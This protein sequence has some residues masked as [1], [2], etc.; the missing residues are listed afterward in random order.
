MAKV[1][2]DEKLTEEE[3]LA[4]AKEEGI[5]FV[6]EFTVEGLDKVYKT[7]EAAKKAA[8]G[9]NVIQTRRVK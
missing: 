9:K 7:H 4:R 5:E 1:P 2:K 3:A 8:K 6:D